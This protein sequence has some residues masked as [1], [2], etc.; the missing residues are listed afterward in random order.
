MTGKD[1]TELTRVIMRQTNAHD[2]AVVEAEEVLDE[3]FRVEGAPAEADV[4]GLL[5]DGDDVGRGPARDAEADGRD[6]RFRGGRRGAVD[7]YVR[8]GIQ[9][10]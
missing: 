3:T 9:V 8:T 6:A 10:G 4:S 7:G 2:P 1:Q 5:N